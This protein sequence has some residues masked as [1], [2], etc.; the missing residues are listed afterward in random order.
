MGARR[1]GR[2]GMPAYDSQQVGSLS[3]PVSLPPP[4]K[5][6][7]LLSLPSDVQ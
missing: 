2:H 3:R 7:T 1:D 5:R 6:L 4:R